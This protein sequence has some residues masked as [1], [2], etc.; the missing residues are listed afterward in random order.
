LLHTIKP[1]LLVSS[2]VFITV[3]IRAYLPLLVHTLLTSSSVF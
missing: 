1:S 2:I 3:V